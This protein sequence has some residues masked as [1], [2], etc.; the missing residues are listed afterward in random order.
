MSN[1]K[2]ISAGFY[3]GYESKF[4]PMKRAQRFAYENDPNNKFA[5]VIPSELRNF[6]FA[7]AK[8]AE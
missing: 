2:A 4:Y 6:A 1:N 8:R 3:Y 7:F 5:K